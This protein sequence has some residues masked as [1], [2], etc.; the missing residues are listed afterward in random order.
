MAIKPGKLHEHLLEKKPNIPPPI[1][2]IDI[3]PT[4]LSIKDASCRIY[5]CK[6]SWDMK[7]VSTDMLQCHIW[8]S[9]T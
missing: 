1:S 3:Q 4:D 8:K 6:G 7:G 5:S 2:S 9:P